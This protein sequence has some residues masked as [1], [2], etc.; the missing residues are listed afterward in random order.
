MCNAEKRHNFQ[1]LR[2]RRGFFVGR[3]IRRLRDVGRPGPHGVRQP[4]V[5]R[6]SE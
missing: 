4:P 2:Q 5:E 6:G 1:Q 3:R